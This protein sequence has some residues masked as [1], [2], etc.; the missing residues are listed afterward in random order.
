MLDLNKVFAFI[1]YIYLSLYK[2][3]FDL[4]IKSTALNE[5]KAVPKKTLEAQRRFSHN[6]FDSNKICLNQTNIFLGALL[7]LTNLKFN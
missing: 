1:K 2:Y 4:N 5:D 7:I 6:I 3:L